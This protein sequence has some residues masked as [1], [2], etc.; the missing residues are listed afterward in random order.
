ML[1]N[2]NQYAYVYILG[3]PYITNRITINSEHDIINI[4]MLSICPPTAFRP[5][6]QEGYLA[7]TDNVTTKY[8]QK[9]E[10]D[11]NNRLLAKFR[12]P[13]NKSFWGSG[14]NVIPEESLYPLNDPIYE[15]CRQIKDGLNTKTNG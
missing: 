8:D 11:F 7:G 2:G 3:S 15:L 4:R 5:Y 10:L 6:F 1:N 13:N 12:I 14:F 9:T